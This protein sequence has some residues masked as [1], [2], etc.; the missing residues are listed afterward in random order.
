MV[1]Y[2]NEIDPYPAQWLRNLAVAGHIPPG[3]VD[4]RS[5]ADVRADDLVGYTQAH[6]FA[7][8]GGWPY[9]LRLAG[10]PDEQP[11]WTG[12]CPCQPFSN[13]GEGLGE[14]DER[15]LWPEMFRLIKECR[16]AIVF[17]EQVDS[18]DGRAWFSSVRSDMEDAEYAMGGGIIPAAG[19]GA[20]HTR[21][22]IFWV[23]A[24]PGLVRGAGFRL[25]RGAGE[26]RPW[27]TFGPMDLRE[28]IDRPFDPGTRFGRPR[29]LA[30]SDG[31]PARVGRLRAY[32]N[33]ITPQVGAVFVRAV[34]DC[35]LQETE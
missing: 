25:A 1:N 15:H 30:I 14:A 33:A 29:A 16:P 7:G 13:A 32:G 6:F 20:P 24:N 23:A 22:R 26:V 17:G 9:A 5:I 10:W 19:V 35:I 18:V 2:Y 4:E 11:V 34:M 27:G 21:D 31:I 28:I 3:T 12:S 8:I